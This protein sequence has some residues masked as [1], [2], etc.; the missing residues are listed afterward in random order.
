MNATTGAHGT[1]EAMAPSTTA[2]VPQE[3]NGVSAPS[4]TAPSTAAQV[5]RRSQLPNRSGLT[6]T[7]TTEA[8]TTLASRNGQLWASAVATSVVTATPK[9]VRWSS[10][11]L[12]NP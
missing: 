3:Q 9:S 2:V 8:T 12:S 4:A 1:E 10:I 6:Y 7:C 11:Y 5:R